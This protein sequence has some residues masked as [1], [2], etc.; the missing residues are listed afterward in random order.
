MLLYLPKGSICIADRWL[1]DNNGYISVK[2]LATESSKIEADKLKSHY[3]IVSEVIVIPDD[4]GLSTFSISQLSAN[5]KNCEIDKVILP[6]SVNTVPL[7]F[8][9]KVNIPDLRPFYSIFKMIWLLGIKNIEVYNFHGVKKFYIPH[10]LDQFKNIHKGQR[11]F[12]VG[13][14]PSLKHIDMTRLKNEITFGSNRCYLGYEDWG[15]SFQYWGIMDRLQIEEYYKEYETS[16]PKDSINFFPFEY[17]P[18]IQLK[19]SCPINHLYNVSGFPKFSDSCDKIYL[20]YTVTYMLIQIAAI[21]GCNQIVL[22]G[23]DHRYNLKITN[24]SKKSS[25]DFSSLIKLKGFNNKIK[26]RIRNSMAYRI[27]KYWRQLK[28][29]RDIQ[30]PLGSEKRSDHWTSSDALGETHFNSGYTMNKRFI[31]PRPKKQEIAYS[32]AERWAQENGI[33][34]LN[35]T[36]GSALKIFPQIDYNSLF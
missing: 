18:L 23:V 21:M 26:N 14:G 2:I 35:A 33:Q 9:E 27:L 13:N 34:I 25:I 15:F 12:I 24:S 29:E 20:G 16:I 36:P 4:I 28:G 6:V 8:I 3:S 5:L 11:C 19:N 10:L 30:K 7:R 1:Q 22:I 17:L 32:C 31:P